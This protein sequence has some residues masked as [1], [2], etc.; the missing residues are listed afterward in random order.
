PP[1]I[2]GEGRDPV[3]QSL[4]HRRLR[5]SH[6]LEGPNCLR[7]LAP[8]SRFIGAHAIKQGRVKMGKAQETLG[9]GAGVRPWCERRVQGRR[10]RFLVARRRIVSSVRAKAYA[11]AIDPRG[12]SRLTGSARRVPP[13]RGQS[14][15]VELKQPRFDR[16]GTTK[17]PQQA[18]QPMSELKLDHGSRIN[19]A[20]ENTLERSV[21]PNMFETR[22]DRLV[23]K[24]ITPSAAA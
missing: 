17:S 13:A 15:T 6:C 9:D 14:F 20:D 8:Q 11:M 19:T 5:L 21:G 1:P 10:R 18:C 22:N 24:P 7:R 12:R 2:P 16:T 3:A 23:S 4:P